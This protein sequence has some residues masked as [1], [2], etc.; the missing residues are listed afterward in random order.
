MASRVKDLDRSPESKVLWFRAGFV[1]MIWLSFVV[2]SLNGN[3]RF[4][5]LLYVL[6]RDT[7][8]DSRPSYSQLGIFFNGCTIVLLAPEFVILEPQT[9]T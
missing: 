1:S 8:L 3:C 6:H 9:R 7:C 4:F 2:P 5:R